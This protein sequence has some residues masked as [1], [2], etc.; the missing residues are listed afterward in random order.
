MFKRYAA[1][2]VVLLGIAILAPAVSAQTPKLVTGKIKSLTVSNPE[3]TRGLTRSEKRYPINLYL[4]SH[5]EFLLGLAF[6]NRNELHVIDH[7]MFL[8][9]KMALEKD[10]P[11]IIRWRSDISHTGP[12]P[13][14]ARIVSVQ[15]GR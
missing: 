11:V 14:F 8:L 15:L 5:P 4:E 9:L 7:E 10:L 13:S 2:L 1:V 3:H 12:Y 6:D